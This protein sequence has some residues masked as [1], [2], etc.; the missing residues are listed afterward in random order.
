MHHIFSHLA[1]F[2]AM[3]CF[4]F[5]CV[6]YAFFHFFNFCCFISVSAGGMQVAYPFFF[7]TPPSDAFQAE[8]MVAIIKAMKWDS[9]NLVRAC[10]RAYGHNTLCR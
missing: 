8:A 1:L 6:L 3:I 7:R 2:R 9:F 5:G 4:R 10:V